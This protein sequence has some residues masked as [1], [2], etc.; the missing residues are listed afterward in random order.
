M[1]W[2]IDGISISVSIYIVLPIE[3]VYER[4]F[5]LT[6]NFCALKVCNRY[7]YSEMLQ[8]L[9]IKEAGQKIVRN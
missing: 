6:D 8:T 4:H 3:H 7:V 1:R 5:A 2:D 9:L